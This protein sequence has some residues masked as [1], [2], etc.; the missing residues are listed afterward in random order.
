MSA[1]AIYWTPEAV[2]YLKDNF[3]NTPTAE[4]AKAFDITVLQ[5][6]SKASAL[7][8]KKD[9]IIEE[10]AP[11]IVPI[12]IIEIIPA[13]NFKKVKVAGGAYI[14]V[15]GHMSIERAQALFSIYHNQ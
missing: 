9:A 11:A 6:R 1:K 13:G 14:N 15:A 10:L 4:L 7:K 12:K 8:L 2:T 3:H 5:V